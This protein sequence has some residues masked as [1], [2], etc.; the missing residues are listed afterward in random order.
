MNTDMSRCKI[1]GRKDGL[2]SLQKAMNSDRS[3]FIALYGRMGVGK[4]F[5]VK[6]FFNNDF[7]FYCTG[8]ANSTKAGQLKAFRSAVERY[9]GRSC[10]RLAGWMDAFSELGKILSASTRQRKVVFLDE[11]PWMDT[12]K[13][14][15]ISALE[16]FWNSD[17]S[18]RG[19]VVLIVCGSATSWM[20]NNLI[21]SKGGLHNRLTDWL[22]IYPF[23]LNECEEY[24]TKRGMNLSRNQVAEYYMIMGGVP[25]YLDFLDSSMTVNEN[26][27]NLFF[28]R[29]GKMRSEF[30][31]LYS[32]L[33][34]NS[35]E[36]V[37]VLKAISSTRSGISRKDITSRSHIESG[38]LLTKILKE[39]EYCDF[40]RSYLKPQGKSKKI[41]QLI[42]PYTIFYLDFIDSEEYTDETFWTDSQN[43]SQRDSWSGYAFEIL[44]LNHQRQIL[45]ALGISGVPYRVS[46][47][48]TDQKRD[49]LLQRKGAQID[50]LIIRK[51]GF[52]NLCE[53]KYSHG[54]FEVSADYEDN[55]RNKLKCFREDSKK[56]YSVIMTLVTTEGLKKN[57]HSGVF[58]RCIVLDDL[59]K[60]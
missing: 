48:R 32:S 39:L 21:D 3:S 57:M 22:Q 13:S 47:W 11:L 14:G 17:I 26:I 20:V 46:S 4:T 45:S 10:P 5:L 59:F 16:Y 49:R 27:D 7:T 24:F 54:M 31:H 52:V 2:D 51:D 34:K 55:L 18:S 12:P 25:F 36:Y 28:R 23:T 50:L 41:Y 15:F 9:S 19:D 8:V 37:K 44:C 33:F 42:D 29:T 38:A 30:S 6:E 58:Q 43:S 35:G 1:I 60:G 56:P 40:I 53:M